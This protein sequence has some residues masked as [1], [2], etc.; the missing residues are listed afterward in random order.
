[1]STLIDSIH[2]R[3]SLDFLFAV[4]DYVLARR[5]SLGEDLSPRARLQS[6]AERSEAALRYLA[7]IL[8][9]DQ[10][11]TTRNPDPRSLD[12]NLCLDRD[13]LDDS[14]WNAF[15]APQ[16]TVPRNGELE[17]QHDTETTAE[18]SHVIGVELLSPYFTF[19]EWQQTMRTITRIT[20]R[21]TPYECPNIGGPE[22]RYPK[23]QAWTNARC[24]FR[25]QYEPLQDDR[26][27]PLRTLKNLIGFWGTCEEP[28][29]R[30][31]P[32]G[33]RYPPYGP[34]SLWDNMKDTV[35][36]KAFR[37]DVYRAA[38]LLDLQEIVEYDKD[39]GFFSRISFKSDPAPSP[40]HARC[41]GIEF[42]EHA[43]TLDIKDIC[44]W[45]GFTSSI[46][47]LCHDSAEEGDSYDFE[48]FV[49]NVMD[50]MEYLKASSQAEQYAWARLVKMAKLAGTVE[51]RCQPNQ[52]QPTP[53]DSR[54]SPLPGAGLPFEHQR[55]L[56]T[57][58][59]P[60]WRF[61]QWRDPATIPKPKI[62]RI[63]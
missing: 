29:S 53:R 62:K 8:G 21:L 13:H 20:S 43:G 38:N 7:V 48:D 23:H 45:I 27:F 28:V 10:P 52:W 18:N 41:H 42:R 56:L 26:F 2:F 57:W 12:T 44:F 59:F 36:E 54:V 51:L 4:D 5:L 33:H 60:Q 35:T 19:G 55:R 17:I 50:M 14:R 30:L 1:M 39:D 6:E 40:W 37:A 15:Q 63:F 11:Q 49:P 32:P 16:L 9:R 22:C 47:W 3:L 31:Q 46:L 58:S 24:S 61:P 25:V 34:Y